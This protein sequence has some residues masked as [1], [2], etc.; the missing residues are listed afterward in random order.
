MT[1]KR[2]L[3]AASG[4]STLLAREF[5]DWGDLVTL[6]RA[7]EFFE[8]V[9]VALVGTRRK[10][11]EL[12]GKFDRADLV[13]PLFPEVEFDPDA[14]GH[15]RV[16]FPGVV[17]TKEPKGVKALIKH[18]RAGYVVGRGAASLV[19]LQTL[20]YSQVWL[21]GHDGGRS[22]LPGLGEVSQRGYDKGRRCTEMMANHLQLEYA[23]YPN[24]LN[25]IQKSDIPDVDKKQRQDAGD[26]KEVGS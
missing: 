13:V 24:R 1:T 17:Q 15:G 10:L 8:H 26:T 14:V 20:G 5:L 16:W 23:F 9:D 25:A 22:R 12:R 2:C 11:E 6:N 19:C 3:F 4:E 18:I 21:F 7:L